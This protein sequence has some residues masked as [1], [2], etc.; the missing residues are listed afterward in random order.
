MKIQSI[1]NGKGQVLRGEWNS[2]SRLHYARKQKVLLFQCSTRRGLEE[3]QTNICAETQRN[4]P[5]SGSRLTVFPVL[6]KWWLAFPEAPRVFYL[7][8]FCK[9]EGQKLFFYQTKVKTLI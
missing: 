6:A 2:K 8:F 4:L 9:C 3:L 7:F 5:Q 1:S